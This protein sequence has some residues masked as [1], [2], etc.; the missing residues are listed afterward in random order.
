MSHNKPSSTKQNVS[1]PKP[2]CGEAEL[3]HRALHQKRRTCTGVCVRMQQSNFHPHSSSAHWH[4]SLQPHVLGG[5]SGE[6]KA[7]RNP[8]LPLLN[9]SC[10][11]PSGT[12]GKSHRLQTL[13]RSTD[14]QRTSPKRTHYNTKSGR[15]AHH[16]MFQLAVGEGGYRVQA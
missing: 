4:C 7:L 5:H 8:R 14:P 10:D 12:Q 2:P 15:G 13:E 6:G 3:T 11:P 16:Q 1:T 9:N